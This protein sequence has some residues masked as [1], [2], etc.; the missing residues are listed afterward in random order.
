[1]TAKP[2]RKR[3]GRPVGDGPTVDLRIRVPRELLDR[4][5]AGAKADDRSRDAYIRRLLE[6]A[7]RPRCLH[8]GHSVIAHNAPAGCGICDQQGRPCDG[9]KP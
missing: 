4:I 8:C 9:A 3:P 6:S 2:T 5:D 1:M 7:M